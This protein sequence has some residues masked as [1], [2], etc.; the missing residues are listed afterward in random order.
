MATSTAPT[1]TPLHTSTSSSITSAASAAGRPELQN[2][3]S[4]PLTAPTVVNYNGKVVRCRIDRGV[5]IAEIIKQLCAAPQ[6]AVNESPALFALRDAADNEL[7]TMDN[8]TRKL[9]HRAAFNLV[10][11]PA[12]EAAQT[13]DQLAGGD[14][15]ATKAATFAL[16][17]RVRVSWDVTVRMFDALT[18]FSHNF[19]GG[20][21]PR[22]VHQAGRCVRSRQGHPRIEWQHAGI[23]SQRNAIDTRA[24]LRLRRP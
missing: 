2:P 15:Q 13:I 24:R 10:P 17:S 3:G 4:T 20:S 19:Q 9:E 7:L 14:K 21:L 18:Y 23:R 22:R 16:K 11:A 5:P 12:I 8:I 1:S 6:L